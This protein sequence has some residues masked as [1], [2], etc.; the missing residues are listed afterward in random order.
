M[1]GPRKNPIRAA[2]ARKRLSV[3]I[4]QL[5]ADRASTEV[6]L[7]N[8]FEW[9]LV[10]AEHRPLNPETVEDLVRAA[11]G[12]GPDKGAFVRVRETGRGAIQYALETG[13][14]GV[15]VP[16][17]G[18]REQ[19]EEVAA[20]THYPPQ[21]TRGLNGG[22]RAAGW[23]QKDPA[24]YARAVNRNLVVAVQIETVSGLEAVEG[25][26]AVKG[27]DMLYIGPFDLS[28]GMGL[29]GQLDHPEVR[30][31]FARVFAAGRKHGKWLGVLAPNVPFAQWCL[32]QGVRFLTYLSDTRLLKNSVQREVEA[33][34]GLRAK[35]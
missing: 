27:I 30:K 9:I 20:L 17:V 32:G 10:D 33:L 11:Q 6:L 15:L 35:R 14:D 8:G 34:R 24:A 18:S 7:G 21:G 25:I 31:A 1:P 28:H 29:T 12:C 16:L 5:L 3:G 22:T 2:L 13:A 26:A 23:G 4:F 19:A